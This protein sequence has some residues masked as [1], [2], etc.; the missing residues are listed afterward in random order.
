MSDTRDVTLAYV[1]MGFKTVWDR[2]YSEGRDLPSQLEAMLEVIAHVDIADAEPCGDC[3]AY[4]V[5]EPFG[6]EMTEQYMVGKPLTNELAVAVLKLV[7]TH[8]CGR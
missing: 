4:D 2:C 1:A 5:A 3:H 7:H 8:D 6:A